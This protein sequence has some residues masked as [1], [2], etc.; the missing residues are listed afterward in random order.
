MCRR[1]CSHP[2][3]A[4]GV[5][6]LAALSLVC[7][8]TAQELE[9]KLPNRPPVS[10]GIVETDLAT[11]PS[12]RAE[13]PCPCFDIQELVVLSSH[14]WDICHRDHVLVQVTRWVGDDVP[15]EGRIGYH[16]LATL[17]N[18][19]SGSGTC[20]YFLRN[21][22]DHETRT[23]MRGWPSLGEQKARTCF[24]MVT[25]WLDSID[26]CPPAGSGE[27]SAPEPP[28]ESEAPPRN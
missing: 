15:P 14:S 17:P 4:V 11:N 1:V 20:Q 27:A 28:S 10:P 16:I 26:A 9:K 25:A 6:S 2:R 12:E 7:R 23:L 18:P 5:A 8:L 3:L 13:A 22:G 21:S 24:E 19:R